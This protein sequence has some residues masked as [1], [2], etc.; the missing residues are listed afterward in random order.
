MEVLP[1]QVVDLLQSCRK[2]IE[3]SYFDHLAGEQRTG[4]AL[5][6]T[7]FESS[8]RL[9]AEILSLR[10]PRR[11]RLTERGYVDQCNHHL[12]RVEA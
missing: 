5:K 9:R 2:W 10:K 11:F 3:V 6:N 7:S 4:W 1:N 12:G 8:L